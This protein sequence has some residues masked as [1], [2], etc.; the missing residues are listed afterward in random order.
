ME[1]A[2]A[3]ESWASVVDIIHTFPFAEYK[4][5]LGF[6]ERS[7]QLASLCSLLGDRRFA[8]CPAVVTFPCS[9]YSF[10]SYYECTPWL[11]FMLMLRKLCTSFTMLS[12]SLRSARGWCC[13]SRKLSR[14]G[15]LI[16]LTLFS[17]VTISMASTGSDQKMIRPKAANM[18]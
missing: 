3:I 8:M 1:F 13:E 11:P 14:F 17:F 10:H 5:L 12:C 6:H 9:F 7:S 18:W 4:Y 2:N 16:A 15:I